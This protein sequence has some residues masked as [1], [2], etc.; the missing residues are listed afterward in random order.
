MTGDVRLCCVHNI[1]F[2]EKSFLIRITISNNLPPCPG[3]CVSEPC[4]CRQLAPL[5]LWLRLR[6]YR[7]FRAWRPGWVWGQWEMWPAS[8]IRQ[9]TPELGMGQMGRA[10]IKSCCLYL[11]LIFLSSVILLTSFTIQWIL[12]SIQFSLVSVTILSPSNNLIIGVFTGGCRCGEP[13]WRGAENLWSDAHHGLDVC[14]QVRI[15]VNN[16]APWLY[17][18]KYLLL[19]TYLFIQNKTTVTFHRLSAFSLNWICFL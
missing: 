13:C 8:V 15:R 14:L 17:Q 7:R 6:H 5:P 11:C 12:Y 1:V 19:C 10:G 16:I 4:I 9:L 18:I 3:L 2:G